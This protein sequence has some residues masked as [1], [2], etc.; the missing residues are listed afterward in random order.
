ML[1]VDSL[2]LS[3]L[4]I[5]HLNWCECS[6]ECLL[7]AYFN[8]AEKLNLK[9]K[10][11]DSFTVMKIRRSY[12]RVMLGRKSVY[13]DECHNGSFIGA[14]FGINQDLTN[15]LVDNWRPFNHKFIPIYQKAH[16]DK[17]KV[18]AGL[19]CAALWVISKGI[20]IG[21][22]VLCPNGN[23]AYLVGEV[24]SSYQYRPGTALPHRRTVKWLADVVLRSEMSQPLQ[25]STGSIG[26]ISNVSKYS[27]EIEQLIG[28][29]RQPTIIAT[30]TTIEDPSTF[31]LEAHLEEFL[32]QNWK[33]TELGKKYD[34]FEE[35]GE[36]VGQ[37]YPSDT[38]PID[39]LA[40]S[41]DKKELLV[42]ELKRG[43]ASDSVVG[44][45]QR[46]MGF[47]LAELAEDDQT[48][49]GVIIAAE[50]QLSIRRALSV[51]NNISFY[52]YQVSFKLIDS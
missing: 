27:E 47:V 32:I 19:A 51:T 8:G 37:Q 12:Y 31:A 41:K 49:R 44:Q 25:N 2:L 35:D 30:D 1:T 36:I 38:G 26:T 50:D 45:I 14:D 11:T 23:G 10:N 40:V 13:A 33:Q 6:F 20:S 21:D 43:R 39:I 22:I 48:V 3:L 18:S 34:I 28:G 29:G 42:V 52:K 24:T 7:S 16:P 46:Y 9:Q 17:T 5:T 15:E 4:E